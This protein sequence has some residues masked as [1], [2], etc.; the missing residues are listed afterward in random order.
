MHRAASG[1]LTGLS[2]LGASWGGPV[3]TD[4]PLDPARAQVTRRDLGFIAVQFVPMIAIS[5]AF[6]AAMSQGIEG[7]EVAGTPL[8]VLYLVSGVLAPVTAQAVA[9]PLFACT[10]TA[11][12]GSEQGQLGAACAVVR[13]HLGRALLVAAPVVVVTGV[14]VGAALDLDARATGALVAMLALNV[15]FAGTL[16]P[17]YVARRSS[18]LVVGWAGYVLALA[19]WP[20][21]WW[22]PATLGT[23]AAAAFGLVA[24]RHA[25]APAAASWPVLVAAARRG[26]LT[27]MPLWC[28]PIAVLLADP[29]AVDALGL[30]LAMTPAL[31]AYQFFFIAVAGPGWRDLDDARTALS[32]EPI[33]DGVLAVRATASRLR[34]NGGRIL[35][36]VTPLVVVGA[37]VIARLEPD[38]AVVAAVMP[39]AAAAVLLLAATV[40]L[41]MVVADRTALVAPALV[42][43]AVLAALLGGLT[44]LEVVAVHAVVTSACLVVVAVR[45]QRAWRTPEYGLFWSTALGA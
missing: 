12:T 24:S 3:S 4:S 18:M 20:Q 30:F 5:L 38:D 37:L 19:F 9:G 31:I 6:A 23:V 45:S 39:A 27:A 43:A 11:T 44:P 10:T 28:L 16:V 7:V 15:V 32:H 25:T 8:S 42:T 22:T 21:L 34:R 33:A 13:R 1:D 41:G 17:A 26:V 35:L 29:A 40:R 36:I 2:R 14:A